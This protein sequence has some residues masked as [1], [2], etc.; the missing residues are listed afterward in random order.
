M[1][2]AFLFALDLYYIEGVVIAIFSFKLKERY[3]DL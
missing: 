1:H 2:L 3:V